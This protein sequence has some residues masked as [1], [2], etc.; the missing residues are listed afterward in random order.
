M[1]MTPTP[2]LIPTE[3]LSVR[4]KLVVIDSAGRRVRTLSEHMIIQP[5]NDFN[6]SQNTLAADGRNQIRLWEN[7]IFDTTWNGSNE[8]NK[9]VAS[10]TYFIK[11]ISTDRLEQETIATKAITLDRPS[12]KLITQSRLS[13]NP[14]R[15]HVVIWARSMMADVEIK[16]HVYSVIGELVAKLEFDNLDSLNWNIVNESGE[17]IASGI[18]LV[19]LMARDPVTGQVERKISKLAVV[20]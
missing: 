6:L 15:D 13:P 8:N 12:I 5:V 11:A 7:E 18:Y 14:A 9:L 20:R 10:G 16:A 17:R 2:T 4:F 3:V 1:T 19:V